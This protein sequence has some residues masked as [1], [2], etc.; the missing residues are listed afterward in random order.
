MIAHDVIEHHLWW[1]VHTGRLSLAE[2]CEQCVHEC[3]F[4][5]FSTNMAVD[6]AIIDVQFYASIL[7]LTNIVAFI[8][9]WPC[10]SIFKLNVNSLLRDCF[11]LRG[12]CDFLQAYMERKVMQ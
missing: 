5:L 3:T 12:G 6:L 11:V 4:P 2:S 7:Q 9:V 10:H 8:L 1:N